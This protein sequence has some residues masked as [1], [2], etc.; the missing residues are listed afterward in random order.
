MLVLETAV[1][2]QHWGSS[3]Q[4]QSS[5]SHRIKYVAC[6][7]L[8]CQHD[9][10]LSNS[11]QGME[12]NTIGEGKYN[13]IEFPGAEQLAQRMKNLMYRHEDLLLNSQKPYKA[14][15]GSAHL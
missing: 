15:H 14:G 9:T 8:G 5:A 6:T 1:G 10:L 11:L 13:F 3:L 4:S 12:L 7:G 2:R